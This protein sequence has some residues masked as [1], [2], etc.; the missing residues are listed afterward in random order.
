[1]SLLLTWDEPRLKALLQLPRASLNLL[2]EGALQTWLNERGGMAGVR[3]Y[4]RQCPSLT[5]RERDL[6]QVI[7]KH[8]NQTAEYYARLLSI[9]RNTYFRALEQLLP[10]LATYLNAWQLRSPQ[11]SFTR[12]IP[13]PITSFIDPHG[14][15]EAVVHLLAVRQVRLLTITGPGGVGKTRLAAQSANALAPFFE[16][17]AFISLS[18]ISE[19]EQL[20]SQVAHAL[21]IQQISER[22]VYDVVAANLQIANTLLI[23]D[24]F[25]HLIAA[26]TLVSDLLRIAPR[27]TVLVTS[28]QRLNLYGEHEYSVPL[29]DLPPAET[30]LPQELL[31][32]PAVRLFV[33][34]AQA[35]RHDFTLTPKNAAD[36]ARICAW[37]DGLPLAIEL[38]ASQIRRNSARQILQQLSVSPIALSSSARD[39]PTRHR[40]LRN[41]VEWSLEQLGAEEAAVFQWLGMFADDF[42]LEA[43]QAICKRDDINDILQ[44][45]TEKSLLRLVPAAQED[46]ESPRYGML[47]ILRQ[48]ALEKLRATP[49]NQTAHQAYAAY[50]LHKIAYLETEYYRPGP[51]PFDR[52]RACLNWIQREH[53]NIQAAL[54]WTL[55]NVKTNLSARILGSLWRFWQILGYLSEARYWL[56]HILA[57]LKPA[58][59]ETYLRTL[60][61]AGWIYR[62]T[63]SDDFPQAHS[64]FEQGLALAEK[65][66]NSFYAC[67]MNQGLGD[68]ASRNRQYK[69]AQAFFR[70]SLA[71]AEELQNEEEIAWTLVGLGRVLRHLRQLDEAQA[72]LTRAQ[73]IFERLSHHNGLLNALGHLSRVL[74]LRG[75]YHNARRYI[76]NAYEIACSLV[77]QAAILPTQFLEGLIYISLQLNDLDYAITVLKRLLRLA[78]TIRTTSA[79][80]AL[81]CCGWLAAQRGQ[82]QVAVSFYAAANAFYT[83][84]HSGFIHG[85]MFWELQEKYQATRETVL[86]AL[87]QQLSAADFKQAWQHGYDQPHEDM[88]QQSSAWLES[89]F[90]A[91]G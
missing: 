79:V 20:L 21:K 77:G 41:A 43:A 70:R 10:K 17:I 5:E 88:L 61:A 9:G 31:A 48:Y 49:E 18:S 72:C 59:E 62:L 1:M 30:L 25:E 80:Y 4:L 67:V 65:A 27:L 90:R 81:E 53:A 75:D 52:H 35:A 13:L 14:S 82:P 23:L 24:N 34:R 71:L 73:V 44:L 36:V 46:G 64:C 39:I 33:E 86:E 40:T 16:Q 50:Y 68:V 57:Q 84:P 83:H 7:L 51:N 6:L 55:E 74:L 42:S 22:S 26:A 32:Y 85:S 63:E 66:G 54:Q 37:L 47:H 56:E 8:P 38:A 58:P 12:H 15:V 2:N 28:R 19:P 11:A 76:Q 87:Q 60:W 29:L 78:K 69:Q 89:T 3:E 91:T 45:L